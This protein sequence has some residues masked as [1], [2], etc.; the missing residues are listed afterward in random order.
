MNANKVSFPYR[1]SKWEITHIELEI[2][3]QMGCISIG[4]VIARNFDRDKG[5]FIPLEG[6][7]ETWNLLPDKNRYN[8]NPPIAHQVA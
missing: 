1:G 2:A 5:D 3:R 6:E 4:G 8:Q 7:P